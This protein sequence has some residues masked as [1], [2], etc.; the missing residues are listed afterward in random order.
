MLSLAFM[1]AKCMGQQTPFIQ[2]IT[3]TIPADAVKLN[4]EQLL[5]FASEKKYDKPFAYFNFKN[6]YRLNNMILAFYDLKGHF[7]GLD[8]DKRGLESMYRKTAPGLNFHATMQKIN[9]IRILTTSYVDKDV[10]VYYFHSSNNTNTLG[11]N[12]SIQCGTV[13]KA[14]A[15]AVLDKIIKSIRLEE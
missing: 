9:G 1:G 3:A 4:K 14:E 13:D 12:G 8:E 11:L 15:E 2:G 10:I 7:Q 6:I 5:A